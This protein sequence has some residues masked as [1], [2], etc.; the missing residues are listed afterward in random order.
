MGCGGAQALTEFDYDSAYLLAEEVC[1]T[2]SFEK[3]SKCINMQSSRRC[4][5]NLRFAS[6]LY[7]ICHFPKVASLAKVREFAF[8]G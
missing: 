3:N 7:A 5:M 1:N 4:A 2:F 6:N 8:A